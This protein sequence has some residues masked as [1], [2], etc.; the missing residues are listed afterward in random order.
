MCVACLE[1]A[2]MAT[3]KGEKGGRRAGIVAVKGLRPEVEVKNNERP[4]GN[5]EA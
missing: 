5:E 2:N 4:G 1:E 3:S